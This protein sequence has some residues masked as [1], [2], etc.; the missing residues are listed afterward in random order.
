VKAQRS[1]AVYLTTLSVASVKR[2]PKI[3]DSWIINREGRG[4]K[5]RW[6]SLSYLIG[7]L[8]KQL[9]MIKIIK[10]SKITAYFWVGISIRDFEYQTEKLPDG[11]LYSV[12]QV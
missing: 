6:S 11:P 9:K 12:K 5:S 8:A 1:P 4:W 2:T 10:P 7:V 3:H